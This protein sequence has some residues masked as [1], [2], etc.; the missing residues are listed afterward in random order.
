[1]SGA[2][3]YIAW[4]GS[5][6]GPWVT[7]SGY[8]TNM[9]A[10]HGYVTGT[11]TQTRTFVTGHNGHFFGCYDE[12]GLYGIWEDISYPFAPQ[13]V[14][15]LSGPAVDQIS[16]F[17]DVWCRSGTTTGGVWARTYNGSNWGS[18]WFLDYMPW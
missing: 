10:G 15:C 11:T 14:G 16:N 17:E 13:G 8:S 7:L 4:N 6:W 1:M 9:P 5:T 18:W 2:L 3:D 12:A